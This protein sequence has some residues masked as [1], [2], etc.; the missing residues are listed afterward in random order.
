VKIQD[1]ERQ[2]EEAAASIH[3]LQSTILLFSFIEKCWAELDSN[4]RRL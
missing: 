2:D 1:F 3:D 4:Q